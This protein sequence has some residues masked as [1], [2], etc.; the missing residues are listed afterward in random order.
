M[1]LLSTSTVT[2]TSSGQ[3]VTVTK[4][5]TVTSS[6]FPFGEASLLV[7]LFVSLDLQSVT[8]RSLA[9]VSR[10]SEKMLD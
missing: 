1:V 6:E 4:T 7:V 9:N 2:V 10:P 5:T 3:P 8:R